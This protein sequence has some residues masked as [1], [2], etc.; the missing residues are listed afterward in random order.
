MIHK[1]QDPQIRARLGTAAD[2]CD[3]LLLSDLPEPGRPM[4]EHLVL[5]FG[6]LHLFLEGLT[7]STVIIEL[8]FYHILLFLGI[9]L[10]QKKCE[11]MNRDSTFALR[12]STSTLDVCL[13]GQ[14][15]E[16][17]HPTCA[18]A[19]LISNTVELIPTLGALFL[20]GGPI[21][22]PV[23][24]NPPVPYNL[25]TRVLELAFL[26]VERAFMCG[27]CFFVNF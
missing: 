4:L 6:S 20:R 18:G 7:V 23:L 3:D 15:R 26:C 16:C 25:C 2:F 10:V 22:D 21:Q 11:G 19:P 1:V 14:Q 13:G 12:R 5:I 17:S 9:S 8:N 27:V 24:T